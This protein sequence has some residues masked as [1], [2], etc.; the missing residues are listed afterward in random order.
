[1]II[2]LNKTRAEVKV[3][4][5]NTHTEKRKEIHITKYCFILLW[6]TDKL[7]YFQNKHT[8]LLRVLTLELDIIS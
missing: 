3:Y 5:I 1:M 6:R 8:K 2:Q 4:A 7:I